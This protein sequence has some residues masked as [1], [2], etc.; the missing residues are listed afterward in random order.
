[1][2][3]PSPPGRGVPP[4]PETSSN[5]EW[6][7]VVAGLGTG[8]RASTCARAWVVCRASR[9]IPLGG[10]LLHPLGFCDLW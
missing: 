10:T 3:A 1:M 4:S 8:L 7:F 5:T 2:I 9:Q 6:L